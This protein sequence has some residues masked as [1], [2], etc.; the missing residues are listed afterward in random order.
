MSAGIE[1]RGRSN[2]ARALETLRQ[3]RASAP[4]ALVRGGDPPLREVVQPHVLGDRA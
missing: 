1:S 2:T 3:I 4:A